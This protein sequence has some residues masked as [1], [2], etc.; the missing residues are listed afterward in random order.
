MAAA[1][2]SS[3]RAR[4]THASWLTQPGGRRFI[5]ACAGNTRQTGT[6][7]LPWPVHPRVRGEHTNHSLK[8]ANGIGSSPRARGT[9][10]AAIPGRRCC[11]F[12]P[13]CAG[14]TTTADPTISATDGSSPRARGT[15]TRNGWQDFVGRFIPACAG[16]TVS[17]ES[18]HRSVPVHPRVRGEHRSQPRMIEA[19]V[20]SSPRARGTRCMACSI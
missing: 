6:A 10:P 8:R 1:V 13:A 4:G 9:R 3:P 16:N 7:S 18:W 11:R 2:G 20:G 14:N 15:L 12:I 5:P 19:V 17:V